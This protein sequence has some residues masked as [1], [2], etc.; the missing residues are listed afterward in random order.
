MPGSG[1]IVVLC[2]FRWNGGSAWEPVQRLQLF[3]LFLSLHIFLLD[4]HDLSFGFVGT[5][6]HAI[7]MPM[8]PVRFALVIFHGIRFPQN[9]MFFFSFFFCQRQKV[10]SAFG[11]PFDRSNDESRF[12]SVLHQLR[13]GDTMFQFLGWNIFTGCQYGILEGY[14]VFVQPRI[15]CRWRHNTRGCHRT[16]RINHDHTL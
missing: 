5:L 4:N 16:G 3:P 15:C 1:V 7:I 10:A 14:L 13:R 11:A 6:L 9:F 2:F 12:H 8:S